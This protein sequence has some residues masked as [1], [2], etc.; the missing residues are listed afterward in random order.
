[1]NSSERYLKITELIDEG[2]I[3]L[4]VNAVDAYVNSIDK[5]IKKAEGK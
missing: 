2:R 3:E 5:A 1:M 4:K